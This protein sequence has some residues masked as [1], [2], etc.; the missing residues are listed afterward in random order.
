MLDLLS[1]DHEFRTDFYIIVAKDTTAEQV[2]KI[3]SI[4]LERIPASKMFRSLETSEKA[5]AATSGVKLDDL[6]ASIISGGKQ[7]IL[8]GIEIIGDSKTGETNQN[9]QNSAP[10][11]V[12]KFNGIAAFKKDK[13]IGWLDE[14]ESKGTNYILN[15]V[16]STIVNIPCSDEGFIGIDLIRSK[17]KVTGSVKNETPENTVYI[18]GEANIADVECTDVDLTNV[19]TI[20][21]LEMKAEEDVKNKIEAA[22]KKSQEDLNTDIFGFGEAIHRANPEYWNKNKSNWESEF[23]NLLVEVKVDIKIR[24]TGTVGNSFLKVLEE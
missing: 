2:L 15:L 5:W 21:E 1:R 17:T 12:L 8:T 19:N 13:L 18:E 4:P 6:L 10:P 7:P 23:A 3:L 9:L 24:R 14:D 16:K 20:Y 22:L 11:A